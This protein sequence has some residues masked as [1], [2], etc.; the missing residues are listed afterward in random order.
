MLVLTSVYLLNPRE[1]I[2]AEEFYAVLEDLCREENLTLVKVHEYWK[3]AVKAGADHHVLVQGD[4][5][6]PTVEGYRLMA[7]AVFEFF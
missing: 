4:G 3:K 6:H 5:V 2:V 7:E 1:N